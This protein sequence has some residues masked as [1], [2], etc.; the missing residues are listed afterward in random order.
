M[1][2]NYNPTLF[3]AATDKGPARAAN[4]DANNVH[5]I[6]APDIAVRLGHLYIVA[7]GVGGQKHGRL[8]ADLAV[9]TIHDYFYQL[10]Q[11]GH[12]I[13]E[14]L[15]Q[16][17]QQA[18]R[19]IY[20]ES[21][22]RSSQRMGCTVV[23]AVQ[24]GTQLFIAHVGDARAYLNRQ[25]SLKLLTR[26]HSWIQ[27]QIDA[28]V[29]DEK[30]ASHHELRH[31]ITRV[32]G[33]EPEIAVDN[34]GPYEFGK[35][36]D[37]LLLCSDGL[38]DTLSHKQ[39]QH[40]LQTGTAQAAATAL[41]QAAVQ[42]GAGDNITAFVVAATPAKQ[43]AAPF[44]PAAVAKKW[45]MP[46]MIVAT[47]LFVLSLY[48]IQSNS[49]SN[50]NDAITPT[51]PMSSI[52]M[53]STTTPENHDPATE[54]PLIQP[55]ST[56]APV[57]TPSPQYCVIPGSNIWVDSPDSPS[58][59]RFTDVTWQAEWNKTFRLITPYDEPQQVLG[60]ISA[61]NCDLLLFYKVE[62]AVLVPTNIGW[63]WANNVGIVQE[64]GSCLRE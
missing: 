3:G 55:T 48:M 47:G 46:L 29:I 20:T 4:E 62:S 16:A 6:V 5:L 57:I 9:Q 26:D 60:Q 23:A 15:S 32:L 51:Q 25:G 53:S 50:T 45:L 19:T 10:R 8:A 18:N 43:P 22:A 58:L 33:N 59:C 1:T 49:L 54:V 37:R 56:P 2:H 40:L 24:Q 12:T 14:A 35:P 64:D 13:P 52:N 44:I 39:L 28:G 31:V 7:D 61:G 38:H 30:H 36:E 27:E 34:R 41:V 17:I 63:V 42:A 11:N 21:Q